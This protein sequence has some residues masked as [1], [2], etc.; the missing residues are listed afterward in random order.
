MNG[1]A[2]APN[3]IAVTP[4]SSRRKRPRIDLRAVRAEDST[5]RFGAEMPNIG[6]AHR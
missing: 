3:S 4:R 5:R 6:V 1:V 2:T